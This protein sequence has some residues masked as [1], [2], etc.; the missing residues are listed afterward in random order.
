ML[1]LVYIECIKLSLKKARDSFIYLEQ[2]CHRDLQFVQQVVQQF[3][4][5]VRQQH[6]IMH[7]SLFLFSFY[8]CMTFEN[9]NTKKRKEKIIST[10][11]YTHAH[12]YM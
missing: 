8:S 7:I 11:K 3:L 10:P 9:R 5:S 6:C 4:F 12:T 2:D 1:K